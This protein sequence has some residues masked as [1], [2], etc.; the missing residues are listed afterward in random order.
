M[1]AIAPVTGDQKTVQP[2]LKGSAADYEGYIVRVLLRSGSPAKQS[3]YI[4][5]TQVWSIEV[6][7]PSIGLKNDAAKQDA[8]HDYYDAVIQAFDHRTTLALP[9]GTKLGGV[10]KAVLGQGTITW[11]DTSLDGVNIRYKLTFPLTLEKVT[12]CESPFS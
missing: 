9:D 3:G 2:R 6:H 5:E 4:Q 8:M 1:E 11:G 12:E 10:S 7:S